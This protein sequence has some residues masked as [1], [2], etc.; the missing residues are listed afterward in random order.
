MAG[1]VHLGDIGTEFR[2]TIVDEDGTAIDISSSSTKT[3]IF[4]KPDG[5]KLEKVASFVNSGTDG[6]LKYVT[7][8]GDLDLIGTWKIQAKVI[9]PGGSWYSNFKSFKVYRN[10]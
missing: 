7:I 3:V 6:L 9:L 1:E 5:T 10:L 8:S 2:I 4:K